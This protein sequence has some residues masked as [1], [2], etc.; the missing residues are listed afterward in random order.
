MAYNNSSDQQG[1]QAQQDLKA[2]EQWE[3]MV[4]EPEMQEPNLQEMLNLFPIDKTRQDSGGSS[5]STTACTEEGSDGQPSGEGAVYSV[6][7]QDHDK[8]TCKPCLFV[9]SPIGCKNGTDCEFCH[10][11]HKRK[12]T[13]RPCKTKRNRYRKLIQKGLDMGAE[14]TVDGMPQQEDEAPRAPVVLDQELLL[15]NIQM[16]LEF[17]TLKA[18]ASEF[19]PATTMRQSIMRP[20]P[21]LEARF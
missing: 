18:K 13:M 20:P 12:N 4:H 21:G 2:T 11:A 3:A 6:G 7:S 19:L 9:K 14:A 1:Q 8:G 17:L 5:E 10:L 15:Q 16:Q